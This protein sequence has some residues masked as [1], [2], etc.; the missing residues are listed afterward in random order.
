[1]IIVLSTNFLLIEG[2]YAL[3][4]SKQL[5]LDAWTLVNEGF[6]DPDK[7]DEIQGHF[8]GALI[9]KIL[10][11]KK[12]GQKSIQLFGDGAP[13]R[14]FMHAKDLAFIIK[15]VVDKDIKE[16]LNASIEPSTSPLIIIFNSLPE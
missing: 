14:Q 9:N 1:M 16:S 11:A 13:L 15:E 3:S 4:D 6:Y 5:V 7:F 8:V 12:N 2:V 10:I